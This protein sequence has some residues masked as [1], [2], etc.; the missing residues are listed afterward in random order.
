ML[1]KLF[2]YTNLYIAAGAAVA[3]YGTCQILHLQIL[4][5]FY[6]FLFFATLCS[7]NFHWFFTP[8]ALHDRE[9]ENWSVKNKTIIAALAILSAIGAAYF[10]WQLPIAYLFFASPLVVLS[11]IYTAPKIPHV[12]F[13]NFKKYIF[14]KTIYLAAAWTYATVLLPIFI[15][16]QNFS[17]T[18]FQYTLHRFALL[19]V[20]CGLFDYRDK[21]EDA[22]GG[23]KSIIALA[24]VG[25]VHIIVQV[26]IAMSILSNIKLTDEI[27]PIFLAFNFI[28]I[29]L[30][31][32]L[33]KRNLDSKNE[34]YYYFVLDGL[35]FINGA[36]YLAMQIF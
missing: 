9:R 27:K 24:S 20:I 16:Q 11:F 25:L 19:L 35:I 8:D 23:I 2:L 1:K 14:A 30:I 33:Y 26:L 32:F 5:A 7:Y 15:T 22:L 28:P 17:D 31:M 29:L 36:I 13:A 18:F 34:V 12:A 4:N 21:I 3:V 6:P 10:A